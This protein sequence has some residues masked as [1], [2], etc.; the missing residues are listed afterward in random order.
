MQEVELHD[1]D[2]STSEPAAEPAETPARARRRLRWVV[3]GGVAVALSLVGTQWVVDARENAAVARLAAVPGV[4][5]EFGEELTVVRTITRTEIQALWGG[6]R[7]AEGATASLVV[8]PDGSQAFTALDRS[9]DPLWSTP[10]VGPNEQRA[11]SLENSYGG[12]CQSDVAPE[13]EASVVVCVATD[14]FTRFSTD[15]ESA[16]ERVPATTTRAVV[17]DP[18]DG[19]VLSERP[20]DDGAR[21]VVLEGQLL[22]GNLRAESIDVVAYDLSTGA[23]RWRYD[24]PR[25]DDGDDG[26]DADAQTR[27]LYWSFF[28][29]GDVAVYASGRG[30]GLLSPTGASVRDDLRSAAGNGGWG[31]DPVTGNLVVF[32]YASAGA[33]S[34]TLLAADADPDADLVLEGSLIHFVVDDLSVPGLVLTSQANAQAWDRRTGE[35]LWE[36]DVQAAGYA[37]VARGRV[38]LTTA[39]GIAAL[40]G[41]T[42][43]VVWK[44]DVPSSSMGALATDGRDLLLSST[45]PGGTLEE[46]ADMTGGMTG[47]DLATGEKTRYIPYPEGVGDVQS[48]RGL[49]IGWSPTSD[50]TFLLE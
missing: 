5:P 11:A 21:V 3:A 4:L 35:L 46:L 13:E 37:L 33:Q 18:D 10:L 20:V 34:T 7:T 15:G 29:A 19:R 22:V 16:D 41:R 28:R 32:D 42:G 26:D 31:T 14:G 24:E 23:E 6:I 44:Q 8:A 12:S 50:D 40:D 49:L 36:A 1:G 45:F 25:D 27:A 43:A 38:Y 48:F 39:T 17:L 47:Y 9:G 30:V 2:E